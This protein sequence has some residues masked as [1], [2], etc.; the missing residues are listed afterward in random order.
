LTLVLFLM[1]EA[2][3][4]GDSF[5]APYFRLLPLSFPG[6]PA[7]TSMLGQCCATVLLRSVR[8][9]H[10]PSQPL[11]PKAKVRT[12]VWA[13]VV[14][15]LHPPSLGVCVYSGHPNTLSPA[16]LA[17]A[18]TIGAVKRVI[19]HRRPDTQLAAFIMEHVCVV[20]L[21]R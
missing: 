15:V 10:P 6:E 8:L 9:S 2:C 14:W 5:W 12:C 16:E 4:N 11:I 20:A 7:L 18:H 19:P 17:V 21:F 13:L 3:Y 1:Y